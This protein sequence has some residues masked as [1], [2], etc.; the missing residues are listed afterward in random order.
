MAATQTVAQDLQFCKPDSGIY[1]LN[2]FVPAVTRSA[3]KP[4][5]G[6]VILHGYGINVR[7]ERGHLLL[8]SGV[9]SDRY[10]GRLSR[11][12]HG[13]ERLVV[14]GADG[15]VSLSALRWLADQK[16]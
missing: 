10:E 8:Q 16:A 14:V 12:G 2:E 5:R 4:R 11:I 15:V 1:P 9:G 6:V 13:L 7:V 3:L